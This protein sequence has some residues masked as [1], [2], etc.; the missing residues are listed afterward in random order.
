MPYISERDRSEVDDI[1]EGIIEKVTSS[2]N[3]KT[4]ID[5]SKIIYIFYKTLKK[6]YGGYGK[7]F[8]EKSDPIR[9]LGCIEHEY[10]RKII[11]PHEE[12]KIKE[13]GDI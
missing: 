1:I 8:L 4:E 2:D 7:G 6:L 3:N 10:Y 9:I 12:I 13:N 11:A 5:S